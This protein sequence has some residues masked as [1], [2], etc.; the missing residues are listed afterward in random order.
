M[1]WAQLAQRAKW[2]SSEGG[3]A[4]NSAKRRANASESR[5]KR[6]PAVAAGAKLARLHG[7]REIGRDGSDVHA[8]ADDEREG[9]AGEAVAFEKDAGA[10][11]AVDQ[12]VI[13]PFER[14]ARMSEP[15]QL[16]RRLEECKTGDEAELRGS[17][18][19]ARADQ[20]EARM[21][22]ARRRRPDAPMPAAPARLAPRHHP[23]PVGVSLP[24]ARE[25]GVVGRGNLVESEQAVAGVKRR[26]TEARCS[27]CRSHQN[28]DFA[29]AA[30]ADTMGAGMMPARM[31]R[32]PL[33][34]STALRTPESGSKRTGPSSKYMTLTMRR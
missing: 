33:T 21:Q 10:F 15:G 29:A 34:A 11:R 20:H 1:P 13:W 4:A 26:G 5:V 23:Q 9:S 22:I 18:D 2:A 14:E 16:A 31:T 19:L 30:A 25:S 8:D 7:L 17:R 24:R 27:F 32:M 12:E 3:A 28:R 6:R